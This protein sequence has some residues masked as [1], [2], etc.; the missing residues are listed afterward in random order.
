MKK[1]I[2]KKITIIIIFLFIF[3]INGLNSGET[4]NNTYAATITYKDWSAINNMDNNYSYSTLFYSNSTQIKILR[5]DG[6]VTWS[7][8][9]GINVP[10]IYLYNG[11]QAIIQITHCAVD[12]NGRSLDVVIK[13][14][15][16]NV[17]RT[18][19][20]NRVGI[21]FTKTDFCNSQENPVPNNGYNYS[22]P[23]TRGEIIKFSLR[24]RF[25]DCNF[26]MTYYVSD[27]YNYN[28]S[29]NKESGV[30]AGITNVNSFLYDLDVVNNTGSYRNQF[31]GGNEGLV[32]NTGN[33][34]I[35]YNKNRKSGKNPA[36]LQEISRGIAVQKDGGLITDGI[37]YK[38]SVFITTT[39]LINSTY[40]FRYGGTG[41]GMGFNFM[42]PYP[43]KIESPTKTVNK[44]KVKEQEKFTYT[45]SQY[46]PNNYYGTLINFNEIYPNLYKNTHYSNI[47]ISDTLDK[48][49]SIVGNVYITNENGENKTSYFD[50]STSNN[51]VTATAKSA[52]L[53]KVEFYAHT[54]NINIP[55]SVKA[56]TGP[57]LI[58]TNSIT[59]KSSTT[60]T[61]N[62]ET[63]TLQSNIVQTPLYYTV[64]TSIKNGTITPTTN[65]DIHN[66]KTVKFTPNDGYYV[67]SVTIDGEK[68]D[69]TKYY[70]GGS[71]EFLDIT[72]DHTVI[73]ETKAYDY[74]QIIKKDSENEEILTNARF[75]LKNLDTGK[76]KTGGINSV[77]NRGWSDTI[78]EATEYKSGDKIVIDRTE[79]G[80]YQLYEVQAHNRYYEPCNKTEEE[81]LKVGDII[82]ISLG[83]PISVTIQNQPRGY[84]VIKKTD[85][86][87]KKE[88]NNTRFII[89]KQNSEEYAKGGKGTNP[90]TWTTDINEA[91]WYKPKQE[92]CFEE[93][94]ICELYEIQRENDSYEYC[95]INQPLKIEDQIQIKYRE[96]INAN[97]TNK[98][99]YVKISGYTWEDFPATNKNNSY[100]NLYNTAI[101]PD[102]KVANIKVK[103][104]DANGNTLNTRADGPAV[105]I[106]NQSGEY[107]FKE[108][109]IEKLQDGAYIEFTYN[110]MAYKA[111]T[112]HP[113]ISNGSKATERT[114][115]EE[116]NNKFAEIIK[117]QAIGN[118][119]RIDLK[120]NQTNY[121]STLDYEGG[122]YG[123]NG[124]KYP[125]SQMAKKYE[126][127]A[128][129]KQNG[130]L[131]QTAF[132][133]EDI[134]TKEIEEI[135]NI[136]LGIVERA[137][138]DI[139]LVKDLNS[140]KISINGKEH[141]YKYADRFNPNLYAE[142]GGNGYNISPQVKFGSKYGNM[143]YTRALYS[144]DIYYKDS[145]DK[146]DNKE[147]KIS[148]T[149]KI[150]IKNASG[151]LTEVINEIE[152]Y[153]DKKYE[154]NKSKIS[155]G[156]EIEENGDIKETSKLDYE[157]VNFKNDNYY[158]IKIK[159][160]NLEIAPNKEEHIY[161]QLQVKEDKIIE[162]LTNGTKLD[163]IAEISSYTNKENGKI[164]AGIDIDS[165]P[166]NI[167]IGNIKTYEDDTDKAPGL[168]L[169]LQE[170]RRVKGTVF[171]D[172]TEKELKTGEIR[173][174]DGIYTQGEVG[175]PEVTVTIINSKTGKIANK[176]NEEKQ[177][178]EPAITTTNEKGEYNIEGMMP[179]EYKIIY[180]WGGQKYKDSEGQE[181]QI[182]VQDYKGTIYQDLDRKTNP[183][184]YKTKE[185]RHS[186]AI[187]NYDENQELPKGS[188]KQIDEQT[189]IITN[190]KKQSINNIG[191]EIQLENG[192]KTELITKMDAT[193]PEFKINVEYSTENTDHKNEYVIENGKIKMDGPYVVKKDEYK[194]EIQNIDFGIVER[195]RQVLELNKRINEVKLT[196]AN[197][198]TMV[199]TKINEDGT[200]ETPAKHTVYIPNSNNSSGQVKFE[201][202]S[203]IVQGAKIEI[204]YEL[205]VINISE[206]EYINKE[207]YIYGKG[208]GENEKQLVELEASKVIDYLTNNIVIE[209]E[210]KQIGEFINETN[211]KLELINQG[212]LENSSKM[213]NLLNSTKEIAI[214]D[215]LSQKLK[216]LGT[217]NN[218]NT[219]I[220][221][222]LKGQKLISNNEESLL[223]NNA[224]IIEIK[225][226]G[227]SSLVTIPGNYIP[228]T[229][230]SEYDNSKSE[231]VEV[232]P[233]TGLGYNYIAYTILAISSLGILVCG[234]ILIKKKILK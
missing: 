217:N 34:T 224:E 145:P 211:K 49:L 3:L 172:S 65:I 21:A 202:D 154:N 180:T 140:A 101:A 69:V 14:T 135:K 113:N 78:E 89:K 201:L 141:I 169:Q 188:R 168:L 130:F 230:I 58:N 126:I 6:T 59:N 8:Q 117:G 61:I 123:Y 200:L 81:K 62:N 103:V 105:A 213:K 98:R 189:K 111:V 17:W 71:I 156:K 106:T 177:K 84:L 133:L 147:L 143:S 210:N 164:Y 174:G 35:Y 173:Q 170:E 128:N 92:I 216:P 24:A 153:Y 73:V 187:D 162:I 120:Y 112:A 33:S 43:Y 90:V 42:S 46:I 15:N 182:T 70:D 93:N 38:T 212:L 234:I 40:S 227:G 60:Y 30:L 57:K 207:Y 151:T 198:T 152:D 72:Q 185:P 183:E 22:R 23:I 203:E 5:N 215:S 67:S 29:T 12:K 94:P 209:A 107:Q 155:I 232:I 114:T 228:S 148:L 44:Q 55:V 222:T 97:I 16:V 66:N 110:G 146:E 95:S 132:E 231:T 19:R 181:K 27:T 233:P 64:T 220:S 171:L 142:N 129:T 197:G 150:G 28:K 131:G 205:K 208:H 13:L 163:N 108:I 75:V 225:K 86:T 47:K 186:D 121:T 100:D 139:S 206:L 192:E 149:Y 166:G 4:R 54:Y 82:N 116:F 214:I 50:I 124:Q 191:G 176:Y 37:W 161:V 179:G 32:P 91:E 204:G 10:E 119:G 137:R 9:N 99:K 226:T 85:E 39:N 199:N 2:I 165:E 79:M 196:L 158:K 36:T 26:T 83:N 51:V 175:I 11:Q 134:Y 31:L 219:S 167:E 53:N 68:Q 48:N 18:A 74:I 125:I 20:D 184:W 76:Y 193:T 77:T 144:S 63:K 157:F 109:E 138:P 25:A 190:D 52:M 45:V 96:S 136:N 160:M 56:Q 1:T 178:W 7:T 218:Q 127:I 194:N 229:N 122:V 87:T 80:R 223:E 221:L 88:L 195:A 159:N 118:K 104:K 41:C 115:R 102:K